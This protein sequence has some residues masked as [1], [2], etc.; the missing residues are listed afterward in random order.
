MT[1][2]QKEKAYKPL[3]DL[4]FK[5]YGDMALV[6]EMD[7]IIKASTK[8]IDNLLHEIDTTPSEYDIKETE[9]SPGVYVMDVTPRIYTVEQF[10]NGECVCENDGEHLGELR[11]LV[12]N[13]GEEGSYKYYLKLNHGYFRDNTL[14][15]KVSNLPIQHI[16]K[17]VI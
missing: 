8:V 9:V 16:S 6:D 13:R 11:K 7:K 14:Y 3:F 17:F 2:A 4:I 5:T 10:R 15:E 12:D 1:E